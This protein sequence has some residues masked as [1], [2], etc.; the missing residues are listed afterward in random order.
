GLF[1]H[2]ITQVWVGARDGGASKSVRKVLVVAEFNAK[3][4]GGMWLLGYRIASLRLHGAL[5]IGLTLVAGTRCSLAATAR[6]PA[7]SGC[8]RALRPAR[9]PGPGAGGPPPRKPCISRQPLA[10]CGQT[11]RDHQC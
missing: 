10:R 4:N 5:R 1:E 9:A 2:W 7:G 6:R 8:P 3:S 11:N